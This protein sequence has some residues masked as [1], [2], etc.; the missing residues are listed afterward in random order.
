VLASFADVEAAL[1]EIQ[2]AIAVQN[3]GFKNLIRGSA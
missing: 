3:E 1:N 2:G